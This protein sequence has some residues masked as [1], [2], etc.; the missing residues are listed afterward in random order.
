MYWGKSKY[1]QDV[2]VDMMHDMTMNYNCTKAI[3]QLGAWPAGYPGRE[4]MI[5]KRYYEEM[6]NLLEQIHGAFPELELYAHSI[7]YCPI[8]DTT[9][10]CPPLDWR[11]PAV[12]DG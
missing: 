2:T 3:F 8:G 11:S 12:I 6:K 4:P 5:F 7:S 1:P 10:V 9:G